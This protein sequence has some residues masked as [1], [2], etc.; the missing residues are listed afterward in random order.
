MMRKY[1]LYNVVL[2][3]FLVLILGIFAS[4]YFSITQH[5]KD[6]IQTTIDEKIILA[7]GINE[8]TSSSY[9]LWFYRT[10]LVSGVEEVIIKEMSKA[11]DIRYIRVVDSF[12]TI[13]QSTIAEEDGK[14]MEDQVYKEAIATKKVIIRDEVFNGEKL[15]AVVYLGYDNKTIWIGFSLA[16]IEKVIRTVFIRDIATTSGILALIVLITFLLLRKYIIDPLRQM[17]LVCEE[18]GKGNLSVRIAVKSKTEI[19][20]LIDTFNKMLED[21]KRSNA[22]LEKAKAVLETKVEDVKEEKNKTLAIISNIYTPIIV[23][24]K[25]NRITLFNPAAQKFLGLKLSDLGKEI[26]D[27]DNFGLN[28]FKSV[29]R[30]KFILSKSKDNGSPDFKTEELRVNYNSEELVYKVITSKVKGGNDEYLGVMKIFLD[31]TRETAI[32]KLK[33]EFVSIAAHQLRT[34][35]SA[36]KWVIKMVLAGDAGELNKEQTELLSKG[37]KSNERIIRLVDD[38]LDISRIEEG[39]FGFNF[40]F[41]NFQEVLDNVVENLASP[42]ANNHLKLIVDKPKKLPEIYMDP[43]RITLALQNLL[44]N[45]VKYTPEFG[46]I[47]ITVQIS[48]KDKILKVSIKDQGV[49]IPKAD[50]PKL[51][52]KFFRAANAV[53]VETEGTGLGLFIA[54]NIIEKHKGE[55]G[56][57]SEEGEGTEVY[58]SLPVS[59]ITK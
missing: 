33:S 40:K 51:F 13:K 57:N 25:D 20:K 42:V 39:R 54:K 2:G 31:L 43:E 12:G 52:S 47:K 37:Y 18:I 17:T 55:I 5:K 27:K 24:G 34:P 8:I 16:N 1:S 15:K 29:I 41:S 53:R 49:G 3:I 4:I 32:D 26:S 28:N 14:T 22:G 48:D 46:Q 6:L 11:R 45:A 21:L 58:F 19:G 9:L 30:N 38:L 10:A 7:S 36:I 50:Q 59:G 44:D 35:L 56:I 23:V